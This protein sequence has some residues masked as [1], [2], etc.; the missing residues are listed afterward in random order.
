VT[1]LE[2]WQQGIPLDR[3]RNI[4]G[5]FNRYKPYAFGRFGMPNEAEIAQMLTDDEAYELFGDDGTTVVAFMSGKTAK[6]NSIK[7]CFGDVELYVSKDDFQIKHL[8]FNS[9][10]SD[11]TLSEWLQQIKASTIWIET[12]AEDTEKLQQLERVGFKR[13]GSKVSA[14]SELKSILIKTDNHMVRTNHPMSLSDKATL[15][16]LTPTFVDAEML[17]E[18]RSDLENYVAKPTNHGWAD[19]YSSYNLRKSWSAISLKGFTN[20]P[21]FII[22]PAE[23]SKKWKEDNAALMHNEVRPTEAWD[24]FPSVHR[25]LQLLG[26]ETQRVRLMRVRAS[27][28]RAIKA[29]RYNRQRGRRNNRKDRT[30]AHPDPNQPRDTIHGMA[31]KRQAGAGTSGYRKPL[32]SGHTQTS[33]CIKPERGAGSHP[34]R[35]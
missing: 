33:R 7:Q 22:K 19:H 3:L 8:T 13:L 34:S 1:N 32:V 16:K 35:H 23:M 31:S 24:S 26:C 6:R 28:R 5:L 12:H 29:R 25:I 14:S 10:I 9:L 21:E 20:D 15:E 18:L 30:P 17:Q 2:A 27:R 4:R 11:S